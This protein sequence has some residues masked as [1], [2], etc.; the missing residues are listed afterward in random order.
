LSSLAVLAQSKTSLEKYSL[1]EYTP[2]I[3]TQDI[4]TGNCHTYAA[5]YVALTTR[6]AWKEDHKFPDSTYSYS[7]G[8]VDAA[9]QTLGKSRISSSIG[10]MYDGY[11]APLGDLDY[12]FYVLYKYGT[13]PFS[14]F[15]YTD[16]RGIASHRNE[17]NT[18]K[19]GLTTIS[20][21][22]EI[23]ADGVKPANWIDQFKSEIVSGKPIIVSI[24]QPNADCYWKDLDKYDPLA[25]NKSGSHIIC[26]I[27]YNDQSKKFLIKNNYGLDCTEWYKYDDVG[28]LIQYA[29]TIDTR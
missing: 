12:T 3:S 18:M 25:D 14:E 19:T 26:I 28:K 24:K 8:Y 6:K 4:P 15:P 21:P 16:Q 5:A 22:N 11:N 9:I 1:Y 17:F 10:E 13:V 7:L 29:Y 20:P 2:Q 23:I 27:G